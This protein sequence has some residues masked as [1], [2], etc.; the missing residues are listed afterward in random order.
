MFSAGA[1]VTDAVNHFTQRGELRTAVQIVRRRTP[2]R[3][4]WRNAVGSLC[5]TAGQLRGLDRMRVEEP[6]REVVID[7]EDRELKQAVV[8]DARRHGVD[9]NRG[10]V[11]PART[12]GDLRRY[13]FLTGADLTRL[14]RHVHVPLDFF[15]PIDPAVV[16]LVG[17]GYAELHRRKAERIWER[18][19]DPG[20]E[21][22][23]LHHRL[24]ARHA[25]REVRQAER[26]EAFARAVVVDPS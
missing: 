3:F 20:E 18:L 13:A 17:R 9:L 7:L 16:V 26:W 25:D 8:L 10:E 19:P 5:Q 4:R 12:V 1:R 15:A 23:E 21:S 11:L 2:E 22:L 14:A 24:M 6:V